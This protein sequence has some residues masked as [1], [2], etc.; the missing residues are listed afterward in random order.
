MADAS[1]DSAARLDLSFIESGREAR[2]ARERK[3]TL[4]GF[5]V[6]AIV[7]AIWLVYILSSSEI[8][9]RVSDNFVP[10]ITMVFG[11][12]VAGSTP[13]GGGAVAFPVFT[14][15]LDIPAEVA[16]SFSLCIQAIGMTCASAAIILGRRPVV[17][18]AVAIGAPA[19]VVGFVT[20]LFLA[21][22]PSVAFWPSTLPGPY[23][24]VTFTLVV[25]AMAWVVLLGLRTPIRRVSDALPDLHGRLFGA[26][27]IAGFLGGAASA[28]VGSGADVFMY[29]FV[30]VLFGVRAGI[31]VPTSV[32]TMA[33]ISVLG[34]LIL[35][36]ADGQLSIELGGT[37][38]NPEVLSVGG[39]ALPAG[40]AASR[41]DLF[42]MWI[43]AVPVVAWGAPLGAFVA[44]RMSP[45]AL[46]TF[47]LSIAA[48]E[49]L[50]TVIFLSELRSDIALATFAIAGLL[51]SIGGITWL[52]SSR[53][54]LFGLPPIDIG[55]LLTRTSLETA[56]SY[57]LDNKE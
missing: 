47:A 33:T 56:S 26:L 15:G 11:S 55:S 41:F 18:R 27:L 1:S 37:A 3:R 49:V 7:S 14:K 31:G 17:W 4:A 48:A 34:F 38:A 42:G 52:A 19:G 23:V 21:G 2:T 22:D 16:R 9:A 8:R 40:S 45:K 36:I 35:G 39:Q 5:L 57:R 43:A 29:L 24:K 51:L 32:I 13:Q 54:R 25:A 50:S 6:S 46:V 53:Q 28:L 44:S 10:A 12:F 30:V 20:T